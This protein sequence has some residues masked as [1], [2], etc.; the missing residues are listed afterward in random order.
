M[1]ALPAEG[2]PLVHLAA[3]AAFLQAMRNNGWWKGLAELQLSKYQ[4]LQQKHQRY[5][6][7][8]QASGPLK[9]QEQCKCHWVPP[10]KLEEAC[11]HARGSWHIA[12]V[13]ASRKGFLSLAVSCPY[14]AERLA[15]MSR[16]GESHL[17]S[18]FEHKALHTN[19]LRLFWQPASSWYPLCISP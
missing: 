15:C 19:A 18:T 5:Q 17:Y 8:L 2:C 16:Q 4:F 1:A 11:P 12:F 10:W 14:A 9:D 6:K 3:L 7:L 13:W